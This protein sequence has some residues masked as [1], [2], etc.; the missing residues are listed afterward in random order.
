MVFPVGL[1]AGSIQ[2]GALVAAGQDKQAALS[3]VSLALSMVPPPGLGL[4]LVAAMTAIMAAAKKGTFPTDAQLLPFR[5]LGATPQQVVELLDAARADP[6]VANNARAAFGFILGEFHKMPA[7]RALICGR[8]GQEAILYGGCV[9]A[10]VKRPRKPGESR[11]LGEVVTLDRLRLGLPVVEDT[12][13][14]GAPLWVEGI[15]QKAI[16]LDRA[17]RQAGQRKALRDW[18][19]KVA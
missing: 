10:G 11:W 15:N 19:R 2:T 5:E 3:A 1:V 18:R 9:G 8:T 12:R 7:V 6:A 16:R 14:Y 17:G 13:S 4:A